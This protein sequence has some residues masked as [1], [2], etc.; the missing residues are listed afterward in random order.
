M[1]EDLI[2][3]IGTDG[4]PNKVSIK[5]NEEYDFKISQYSEIAYQKD[6]EKEMDAMDT[7][8]NKILKRMEVLRNWMNDFERKI[9]FFGKLARFL[10]FEGK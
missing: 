3:I 5:E 6:M 9:S 10:K 2:E 1:G 4:E 7:E 8:E